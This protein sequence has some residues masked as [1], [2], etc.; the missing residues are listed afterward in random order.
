MRFITLVVVV[1][2]GSTVL[3]RE[4]SAQEVRFTG[5]AGGG[6][7]S[8][9]NGQ[10][11]PTLGGGVLV[12]PG[13][14]WLALGAQGETFFQWP[15]FTGRG[16]LF[17]QGNLLPDSPVRPI[18]IAGYGFGE[19]SGPVIGAGFEARSINGKGPGVRFTVEDFIVRRNRFL[20]ETGHQVAFKV[21]VLF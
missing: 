8:D 5:F 15:Y 18:I 19:D 9:M 2:V 4:A 14:R 17:A 13:V 10:R 16:A 11:Y 1:V 12:E 3:A 7:T 6:A 20:R 21:A